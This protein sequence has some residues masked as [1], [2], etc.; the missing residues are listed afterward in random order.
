MKGEQALAQ[1]TAISTK[2]LNKIMSY[3]IC[4]DCVFCLLSIALNKLHNETL[5]V[6]FRHCHSFKKNI[7]SNQIVFYFSMS[8]L[9][10]DKRFHIF[11]TR[12]HHNYDDERKRC[13][14]VA[15]A[16]PNRQLLTERWT[17][18]IAKSVKLFVNI[19]RC[20]HEDC[21][22]RTHNFPMYHDS[23]DVLLA[24]FWNELHPL[25]SAVQSWR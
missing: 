12:V 25:K 7:G 21:S 18:H 15:E 24:L 23:C 19:S 1:T 6:A 11:T 10:I 4:F 13:Y 14:L 9:G 8:W 5:H 3:L 16:K 17:C 2:G 22:L 20:S